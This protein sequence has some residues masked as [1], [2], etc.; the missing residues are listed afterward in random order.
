MKSSRNRL[1][2]GVLTAVTGALVAIVVVVWGGVHLF[3]HRLHYQIEVDDSV[4]GLV[5][6][7]EVFYNGIPVGSVR[8]IEIAPE[9]IR[10][11][12]IG[13]AIDEDTPVRAD[14]KATLAMSGITGTKVV[15]LRAGTP[16]APP[17]AEGS[18]IALG[19]TTFDRLEKE[20]EDLTGKS[21][22]LLERAD[23][24]EA[25]AETAMANLARITD[26]REFEALVAQARAGIA[27]LA[28]ATTAVRGVVDD[29]REPL[30]NA[31]SDLRQASRSFKELAREVREQPSRI[32]ISSPK[33]DRKLP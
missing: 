17:L 23:R 33:G 10:R 24:I 14:T 12:R 9:D 2:V 28:R 3:R 16:G 19:Q 29:N 32:L 20:L 31:V 22:Q 25:S 1:R 13:I 6:G 5:R 11:V 18:T 15:D 27:E 30:R 8:S 26:P 21:R 7:A 4:Y